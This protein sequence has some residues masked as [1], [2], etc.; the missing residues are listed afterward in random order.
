MR[1]IA[2]RTGGR[3]YFPR[4]EQDLRDAFAQIQRDLREQYLVAYSPANKTRDG[5]YRRIQIE[6][7]D[8]EV[9]KQNLKLNYRP[10]YFAKSVDGSTPTRKRTQPD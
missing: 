10:G 7:V 5:A 2:E 1:K 8:P 3:A 4:H 6:V 9:R